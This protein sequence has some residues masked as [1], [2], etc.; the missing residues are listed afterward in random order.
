MD[1]EQ[2]FARPQPQALPA[3][4]MLTRSK[5]AQAAADQKEQERAAEAAAQA[6]RDQQQRDVAAA[7]RRAK[8][9]PDLS[10]PGLAELSEDAKA[11]LVAQANRAA[12]E[13]ERLMAEAENSFKKASVRYESYAE[14][15]ALQAQ[16]AREQLQAVLPPHLHEQ[17]QQASS[18]DA[19]AILLSAV[20]AQ[21]EAESA[22]PKQMQSAVAL[23]SAVVTPQL[24]QEQQRAPQTSIRAGGGGF[25]A[26]LRQQTQAGQRV[27][28]LGLPSLV[29]TPPQQQAAQFA[30]QPAFIPAQQQPSVA[31]QGLLPQFNAAAA[32]AQTVLRGDADSATAAVRATGAAAAAQRSDY[33]TAAAARRSRKLR[34]RERRR[35]WR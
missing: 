3:A 25:E 12:E 24:Q 20:R 4:S 28:F 6:E 9:Q 32:G 27:G 8:F 13:S 22:Q 10:Q 21:I 11:A 31:S 5:S 35:W 15:Q 14:Q 16:H 30:Q 1:T 17:L 2:P 33:A 18:P 19:Q 29:Q 34:G 7:E 26:A 23:P